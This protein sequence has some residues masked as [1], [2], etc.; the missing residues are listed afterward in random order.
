MIS[1]SK[2]LRKAYLVALCKWNSRGTCVYTVHRAI[3]IL[4]NER[5]LNLYRILNRNERVRVYQLTFTNRIRNQTESRSI[6]TNNWICSIGVLFYSN[7]KYAH[8]CNASRI[9]HF[10]TFGLAC[11][12]SWHSTEPRSPPVHPYCEQIVGPP[13]VRR[14]PDSPACTPRRSRA[15]T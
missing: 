1:Q 14:L 5:T 10:I 3:L 12:A 6:E 8:T 7:V 4:Q 11:A 15:R 9:N 2:L 13:P